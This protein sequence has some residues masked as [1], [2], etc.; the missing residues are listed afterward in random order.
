MAEGP[1]RS[2]KSEATESVDY[3]DNTGGRERV[4][5]P[6]EEELAGGEDAWKAQAS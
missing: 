6:G 3:G 1:S 2:I 5:E 4:G